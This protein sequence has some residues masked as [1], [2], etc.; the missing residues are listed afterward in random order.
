MMR[1]GE[2]LGARAKLG[3]RRGG[4][5][6]SRRAIAGSTQVWAYVQLA[7]EAIGST[8]VVAAYD[9]AMFTGKAPA[10]LGWAGPA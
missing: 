5:R 4:Q 3:E 1:E 8:W 9:E 7:G 10:G 2:G 6:P